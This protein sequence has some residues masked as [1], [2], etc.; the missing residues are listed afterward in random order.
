LDL[1]VSVVVVNGLQLSSPDEK[2][3]PAYFEDDDYAIRT[4]KGCLKAV[5]FD[6]IHLIHGQ[7]NGSLG[8]YGSTFRYVNEVKKGSKDP[9][10][11]YAKKL[12]TAGLV[13]SGIYMK[14]KWGVSNTSKNDCKSI[15]AMNN[16]NFTGRGECKRPF[17]K[18]FNISDNSLSYWELD[19]F[20]Q[21][22]VLKTAENI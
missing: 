12:L 21:S 13:A 5:K 16:K 7:L 6:N 14:K 20:A 3:F 1:P 19:H 2:F 17:L 18:P 11:F 8:Y 9:R 15:K 10:V 22:L 4:S